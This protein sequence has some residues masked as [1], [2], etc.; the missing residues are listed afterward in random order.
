MT[1]RDAYIE[2]LKAKLDEWNAQIGK[3]E[4]KMREQ[5]ADARMKCEKELN[6][7]RS[8]RDEVQRRLDELRRSSESAWEDIKAGVDQAWDRLSEAMRRARS[9]F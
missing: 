5:R 6:S 3:M 4:A 7:A 2:K 1:D 8:Y 9:H